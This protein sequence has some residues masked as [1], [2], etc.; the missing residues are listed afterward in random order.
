MSDENNENAY[1]AA[2]RCYAKSEEHNAMIAYHAWKR[3]EWYKQGCEWSAK[4]N[5]ERRK[6]HLAVAKAAAKAGS[7]ARPAAK[8]NVIA[9]KTKAVAKKRT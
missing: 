1:L 9:D 8:A 4:I 2:T 5:D 3:D 6:A 7:I